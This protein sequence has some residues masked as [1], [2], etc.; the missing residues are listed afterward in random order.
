[1]KTFHIQLW[2]SFYSQPSFLFLPVERGNGR[3]NQGIDEHADLGGVGSGRYGGSAA[4]SGGSFNSNFNTHRREWAVMMKEKDKQGGST[5]VC[6]FFLL[7]LG[8][9][10]RS[11]LRTPEHLIRSCMF[12]S[13]VARA[14]VETEALRALAT[15][16]VN[17]GTGLGIVRVAAGVAPSLEAAAVALAK[18]SRGARGARANLYQQGTRLRQM[19][20]ALSSTRSA[21][22]DRKKEETALYSYI[23]GQ[24]GHTKTTKRPLTRVI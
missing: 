22:G 15:F 13:L 17:R 12:H 2:P 5:E 7:T 1:M 23:F 18:G 10:I 8:P 19:I 9:L 11:Y 24:E 3:S 14:E 16:A 20:A 4:M 6:L 21:R